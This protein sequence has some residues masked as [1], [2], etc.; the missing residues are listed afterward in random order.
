MAFP[1]DLTR[2]KNWGNEVLTD[3]DLEGQFDLIVNWVMAA[4]NSS[5]GHSHDGTSNQGPKI[6]ASAL[7]IS[8]QA[9]GD[10]LYASSASAWARL[11]YGTA[12][13][14]LRT[15]GS[16]ANP[17]W[18][19][20]PSAGG[21]SNLAVSRTNATTVA[22]TA[23][24]LT[25]FD[26]NNV[27]WLCTSVSVSPAI[28]ASGANGLDTGAEGSSTWYYIWVIRKSTD[29]TVA[30]LIST[31]STSPTMPSG[32]DQKA[33]VSVVR[34]DGSSN[35]IDFK[36]YGRDYY[37]ITSQT[38]YSG[39]PGSGSWTSADITA[40]VPS[41]LSTVA[42]FILSAGT[43][44]ASSFTND[45]SVAVSISTS[46]PNKIQQVAQ[47]GYNPQDFISS[48]I[49]TAN[50]VYVAGSGAVTLYVNGFNLNKLMS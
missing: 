22:V 34:N 6:S 10:I 50:T 5:T 35:F 44:Q 16:G 9:Q 32:Y 48:P 27:G 23:D 4:L 38:G 8:S 29:G 17:S 1:S 15:G 25:V 36:Q 7:T 42:H 14:Q 43:S 21:F 18:A 30:G 24:R 13:Y 2:T 39:S 31:S 20:P 12:G 3:A 19:I 11:G 49:L 47:T 40:Y 46:A 33:L 28:T 45:S 37:Y 26:T 41:A